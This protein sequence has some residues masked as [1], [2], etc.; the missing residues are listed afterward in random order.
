MGREIIINNN[1][2]NKIVDTFVIVCLTSHDP[3]TF[4]LPYI[5]GSGPEHPQGCDRGLQGYDSKYHDRPRALNMNPNQTM[6]VCFMHASWYYGKMAQLS[7]PRIKSSYSGTNQ[8]NKLV[9]ACFEYDI[10]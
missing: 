10:I 3:W 8:A 7:Q 9:V 2:L 4:F 5:P 6:F 1:C